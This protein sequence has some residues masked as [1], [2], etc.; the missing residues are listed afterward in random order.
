MRCRLI[1]AGA[2]LSRL[3][4][5]PSRHRAPTSPRVTPRV[6]SLHPPD[7]RRASRGREARGAN[8]A[9]GSAGDPQFVPEPGT[10]LSLGGDGAVRAQVVEEPQHVRN[11]GQAGT[12]R[13]RIASVLSLVP[14]LALSPACATEPYRC[15]SAPSDGFA[16]SRVPRSAIHGRRTPPAR[17]SAY[18]T[19]FP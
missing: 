9:A 18:E 17:G 16:N 8:P 1:W 13:G 15:A 2:R 7:Q 19:G 5:I 4:R 11:V 14:A 10:A 3:V 12:H 6:E